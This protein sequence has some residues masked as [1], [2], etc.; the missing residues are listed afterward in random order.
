MGGVA[1]NRIVQTAVKRLGHPE[2][3]V[4]GEAGPVT[5]AAINAADPVALLSGIRYEQWSHYEALMKKNP[6]LEVFRKGWYN[7]AYS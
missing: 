6:K 1:A 3:L 5:V 7:R 4:D 2:V